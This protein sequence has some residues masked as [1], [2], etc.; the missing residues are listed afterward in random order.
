[1]E[2]TIVVRKEDGT[3]QKF[4]R[5]NIVQSM[6]AVGV[7]RKTAKELA[8]QVHEKQAMTEHEIKS[9]VFS[10]LDNIDPTYADR[11]YVTKKVSVHREESQ[12]NGIVLASE[13]LLG[14]L[15]A[16]WGD[17]V[18]VFHHDRKATMKVIATHAQHEDHEIVFMSDHDMK[19]LEIKKGDQIGICKHR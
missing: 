10:L 12:V 2:M 16:K 17:M 14:Y 18:D 4:D 13:Y 5:S 1:M 19:S 3:Y 15:D 8:K 11:Y 6:E 7:D 9:M